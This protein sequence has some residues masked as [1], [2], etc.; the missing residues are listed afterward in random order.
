VDAEKGGGS[1]TV[2]KTKTTEGVDITKPPHEEKKREKRNVTQ[3]KSEEGVGG[4]F[5]AISKKKGGH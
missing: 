5:W 4:H 2:I 1:G 3:G